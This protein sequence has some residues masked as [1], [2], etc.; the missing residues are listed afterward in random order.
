MKTVAEGVLGSECTCSPTMWTHSSV[1]R[2]CFHKKSQ[3]L[4]QDVLS[5][6]SSRR[7][8]FYCRHSSYL[9]RIKWCAM[10]FGATPSKKR[11]I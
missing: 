5:A 7:F 3:T 8:A 4:P 6:F 9:T 11:L 2:L 10:L 1:C